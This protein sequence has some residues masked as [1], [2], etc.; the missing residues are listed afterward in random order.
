MKIRQGFVSNSSSSSF[1]CDISMPLDEIKK[2][3]NLMLDTYNKLH[4]I[5]KQYDDVFRE[6]FIGDE[7]YEKDSISFFRKH[8]DNLPTVED[9]V[10]I[11]SADDN[12]IPY[13][14]WEQINFVF[15]AQRIHLG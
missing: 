8:Y 10:I 2:K 4:I 3:L 6:P 1:V 5:E 12:S 14:L 7:K 15:N 9:K 13:E 11:E